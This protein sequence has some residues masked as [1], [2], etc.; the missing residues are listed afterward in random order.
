[1]SEGNY[2]KVSLSCLAQFTTPTE[3]FVQDDIG[4]RHIGDLEFKYGCELAK[5]YDIPAGIVGDRCGDRTDT[6]RA[7]SAGPS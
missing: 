1:M 3:V 7:V 5:L 4:W 6:L 2:A